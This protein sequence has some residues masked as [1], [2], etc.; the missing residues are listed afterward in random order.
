M[1]VDALVGLSGQPVPVHHRFDHPLSLWCRSFTFIVRRTLFF[2]SDVLRPGEKPG[3]GGFWFYRPILVFYE[4]GAPVTGVLEVDRPAE[5]IAVLHRGAAPGTGEP[6][7][8]GQGAKGGL[9]PNGGHRVN[10]RRYP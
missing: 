5:G 2:L 7:P 4:N 8:D 1:G 10:R 9:L 6:G 3:L